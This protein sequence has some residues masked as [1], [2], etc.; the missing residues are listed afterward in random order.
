MEWNI[1][2]DDTRHNRKIHSYNLQSFVN[3]LMD[4]GLPI[5]SRMWFYLPYFTTMVSAGWQRREREAH[6]VLVQIS[7]AADVSP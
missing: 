2:L 5:L 6:L 3:L 1:V 7:L 4:E